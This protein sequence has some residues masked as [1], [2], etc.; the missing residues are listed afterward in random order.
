M[1]QK[2]GSTGLGAR[3]KV[4]VI[5]ALA[6]VAVLI[7]LNVGRTPIVEIRP[8]NFSSLIVNNS[9]IPDFLQ[10]AASWLS[11]VWDAARSFFGSGKEVGHL[12]VVTLTGEAVKNFFKSLFPSKKDKSSGTET[13][14][15][16]VSYAT[17]LL[18]VED[19]PAELAPW[20]NDLLTAIA[21]QYPQLYKRHTEVCELIHRGL[22]REALAIIEEGAPSQLSLMFKAI[23]R[24][25][26]QQ[27]K[28]KPTG[29]QPPEK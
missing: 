4:G 6:A 25:L 23:R 11:G 28:D 9:N 1:V 10:G 14:A 2:R 29:T 7:G 13:V 18:C 8:D 3:L 5:A 24:Q 12:V 16:P 19:W 21:E 20:R 26:S 15:M 22:E 17:Y 27:S